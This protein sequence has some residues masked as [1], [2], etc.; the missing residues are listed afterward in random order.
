[1]KTI[2]AGLILA[3]SLVLSAAQTLPT[4]VN[5]P[6]FTNAIPSASS[7]TAP[8]HI[9]I[10]LVPK[11]IF[12][13]QI[14]AQA[15]NAGTSNVTVSVNTSLDSA[16]WTTTAPYTGTFAL[17]GTNVVVVI[18]PIG[19]NLLGVVASVDKFATTQTNAVTL[20]SMKAVCIP[21]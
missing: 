10:D 5:T 17:N 20:L 7:S 9:P 18:V 8:S 15:A 11:T 21:Q 19:T 6:L 1:M 2:F 16:K 14:E 12:A 13:L 3:A 4:V